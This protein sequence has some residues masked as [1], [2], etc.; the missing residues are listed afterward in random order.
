MFLIVS[1]ALVSIIIISSGLYIFCYSTQNNN[2]PDRDTLFQIEAFNTFSSGKY[3][4]Y[5][6]YR[7]LEEHGDFGIGTFHALDGEMIALDGRFYQIPIDGKPKQAD[8]SIKAPYATITFFESDIIKNLEKSV[9]YFE[10]QNIIQSLMPTENAIYA[11]KVSGT[12]TYAETRSVPAQNKPYPTIA[13][14]VEN[15][16]IFILNNVS[17]TAVGFWFP[18]SMDGVD[19]SGFHLHL[20]TNDYSAGGHLLDFTIENATIE[21]DQTTKFN[22]ILP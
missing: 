7:E 4:G 20:I 13:K 22:L 15:Q 14:V 10:I 9:D 16:S 1:L 3:D 12:Y 17:A 6:S 8:P 5:M 11:I 18:S 2:I 21:I 19:Y